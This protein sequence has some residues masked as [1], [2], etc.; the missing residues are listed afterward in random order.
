MIITRSRRILCWT[1][2]VSCITVMVVI[3]TGKNYGD[4]E[5][6]RIVELAIYSPQKIL[7]NDMLY[8]SSL[9]YIKGKPFLE[10]FILVRIRSTKEFV[11]KLV[12]Q[13]CSLA[14][15]VL[16]ALAIAAEIGL[17]IQGREVCLD[18]N[19]F[20]NLFIIFILFDMI[21]NISYIISE[22]HVVGNMMLMISQLGYLI[23]GL[24]AQFIDGMNLFYVIFE[25]KLILL[26]NIGMGLILAGV[27]KRKEWLK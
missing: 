26:I 10:P 25:W 17:L 1:I 11:I 9:L 8:F 13:G 6:S 12:W 19:P 2:I 24:M 23:I 4:I 7:F 3:Q 5:S 21:Y 27:L 22:N 20:L 18:L 15:E 14:L 16:L